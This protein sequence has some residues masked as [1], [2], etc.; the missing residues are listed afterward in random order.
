MKTSAVILVKN[1]EALIGDCLASLTW[2]DEIIVV[3]NGCTDKTVEI[4][5]GKGAKIVKS[6]KGSFADR[7][8]LGAKVAGGDW[9][10]YVDVD[11]RVTP[12]LRK[13]IQSLITNHQLKYNAYAI[14]RKNILLGHP[15]RWGGWWPD[16]VL[17]LIKKDALLGWKGELHEQPAIKG[18]VGKLKNPLTHISHRSLSEMV[19]KTNEW[20]AIEAKLLFE[21]GHPKMVWWRFI[22]VA[23]REFRYRAILKLGFLDGAVG[24]I[25][26]IY[27]T[28]SRMITYAKLWEMQKNESRNI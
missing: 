28:F 14:P 2:V 18:E 13:E 4:A 22:S 7:R 26:I 6:L 16:Y 23:A 17:R 9:L 20:S 21:S 27:Q 8:N 10:L 25:E 15:M 12:A 24:V 11:E 5:K 1:E 3:D 19:A